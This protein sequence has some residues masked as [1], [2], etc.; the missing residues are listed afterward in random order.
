MGMDVRLAEERRR[1]V[2][3]NTAS[4]WWSRSTNCLPGFLRRLLLGMARILLLTLL[5]MGQGGGRRRCVGW[6]MG[7]GSGVGARGYAV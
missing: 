3:F 4:G 7:R 5:L 1:V 2:L 6:L